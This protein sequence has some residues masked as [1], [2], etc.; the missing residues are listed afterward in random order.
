MILLEDEQ[1]YYN[2]GA[3]NQF[4]VVIYGKVEAQTCLLLQVLEPLRTHHYML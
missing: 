3:T 1:N 2:E 4:F